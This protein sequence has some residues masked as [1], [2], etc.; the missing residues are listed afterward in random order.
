MHSEGFLEQPQTSNTTNSSLESTSPHHTRWCALPTWPRCAQWS[1]LWWAGTREKTK[2][3]HVSSPVTWLRSHL[4]LGGASLFLCLLDKF[5]C[6]APEHENNKVCHDTY[7]S[8]CVQRVT[9]VMVSSRMFLR[10][11]IDTILREDM[12]VDEMICACVHRLLHCKP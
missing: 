12:R 9:S 2:T 8:T 3:T 4:G 5:S 6:I 1:T 11:S 7:I 10:Y